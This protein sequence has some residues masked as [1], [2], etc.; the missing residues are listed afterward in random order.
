[1]MRNYTGS[2][3]IKVGDIVVSVQGRD[4]SKIYA[5][6]KLNGDGRFLCTDGTKEKLKS[7]LHIRTVDEDRVVCFDSEENVKALLSAYSKEDYAYLK[8]RHYKPKKG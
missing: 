7:P 5:V 1:M 2:D 8:Q 4:C 3:R 6:K